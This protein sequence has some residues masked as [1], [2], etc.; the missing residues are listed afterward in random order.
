MPKPEST[1]DVLA[2]AK[3][4]FENGV[5]VDIH[6]SISQAGKGAMAC[7][8]CLNAFLAINSA[9]DHCLISNKTYRG[10]AL[11]LFDSAMELVCP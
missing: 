4:L 3:R 7:G 8:P 1:Y 11:C 2:E 5:C 10:A 9:G 6:D